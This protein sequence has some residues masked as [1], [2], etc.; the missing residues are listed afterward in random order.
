MK[1]SGSR[2]KLLSLKKAVQPDVLAEPGPGLPEPDLSSVIY[3]YITE[4]T[5]SQAYIAVKT[6]NTFYAASCRISP[7][8]PD[9][10]LSSSPKLTRLIHIRPINCAIPS[11]NKARENN[12]RH[13]PA[14]PSN[15]RICLNLLASDTWVPVAEAKPPPVP[16]HGKGIMSSFVSQSITGYPKIGSSSSHSPSV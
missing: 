14:R 12:A 3:F 4:S 11:T 6:Q 10:A 13:S 2:P 15:R 16:A 1:Q 7:Q 8:T 5:V 9:S